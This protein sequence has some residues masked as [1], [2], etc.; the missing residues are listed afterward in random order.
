MA[1]KSIAA[2]SPKIS[3]ARRR[4][5]ATRAKRE[6]ERA[7][8]LDIWTRLCGVVRDPDG[9]HIWLLLEPKAESRAKG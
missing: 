8:A 3:R 6:A 4:R 7:R 5:A 1:E 2:P 9:E